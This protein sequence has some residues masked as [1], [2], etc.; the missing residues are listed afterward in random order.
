MLYMYFRSSIRTMTTSITSN[1]QEELLQA[2]E[3]NG[4]TCKF[5]ADELTT[6][7]KKLAIVKII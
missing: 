3:P 6:K 5:R 1:H 4:K 2:A 7:L